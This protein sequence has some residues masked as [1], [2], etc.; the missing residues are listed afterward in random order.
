MHRFLVRLAVLS[1]AAWAV[2][3]GTRAQII[4]VRTVPLATGDQFFFLPSASLAMGGVGFALDDSLADPWSNP[5]KGVF[6]GEPTF[7][8][9]PTFFAVSQHGGSGR[10]IPVAGLLAGGGWSGGAALAMQQLEGSRDQTS[11]IEPLSMWSQWRP[12]LLS[13]ESARNLYAQIFVARRLAGGPWSMGV[14]ASVSSLDALEGVDMLYPNATRIVQSGGTDD[15]RVGLYRRGARERL[16]MV[17]ARNRISMTHD[18]TYLEVRWP[19]PLPSGEVG[20]PTLASRV[21]HN[22]DDTRTWAFQAAWDRD[23]NAPGWRA[24]L[25][26]TVNRKSHP[27]IPNY[28]LQ[29]IPRDPGTTW[30]YE[31]GAGLSRTH[32][33]TTFGVDIAL[34]P[35]WS[36]TWQVADTAIVGAS[37]GV[38]QVGERTIE[39]DFSFQNVLL[40]L[41]FDHD[42]G[43]GSVQLGLEARSYDYDMDQKNH[44]S[45]TF[46][47]QSEHWME[48]TPTAGGTLRVS[49]LEIRWFGSATTGS[50]RP[51]V[52]SWTFPVVADAP[53]LSSGDF[54]VAPQGPLTLQNATVWTQQLSVSI[55]IR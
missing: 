5:A 31:L 26:A 20:T 52:G 21:E 11:W 37:G 36:D 13:D 43:R 16:S 27:G 7:L 25:S 46:R 10:T 54:L 23:L 49:G 48:W 42:L 9:S 4:P 24:G 8:S 32:G 3:F 50:G 22:V 47:D 39:N 6:V 55:P 40:R 30:A 28:E 15:V 45:G 2:P 34:Q 38:I 29:N 14:G 1:W 44:V 41:G 51:G 33:P 53:T 18:V 12:E 17:V 19:P 35:I